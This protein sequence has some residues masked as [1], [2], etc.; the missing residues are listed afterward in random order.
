MVH[1]NDLAKTVTELDYLVLL[2][3]LTPETRGIV[4]AKVLGA[5]KK[6]SYL[7]NLARGGVLDEDALI[8]AL[9]QGHIAGAALDVFQTEPLPPEHRFW[10]MKNVIV[11]T[12]QGGFCDTYPDLALPVI[13]TNMRCFLSG[14]TE[15]M[16]NV[17]RRP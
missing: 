7:V 14:N 11:T 6:G 12:H 8:A 1:R 17:V 10:S 15:G 5:M 2:T 9:D 13:E 16:I 3:P 4:N